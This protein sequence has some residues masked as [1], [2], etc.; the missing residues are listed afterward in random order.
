MAPRGAG[1]RPPAAWEKNSGYRPRLRPPVPFPD[2][3]L[4]PV[5]ARL[6][7]LF[8][9]RLL[10][11]LAREALFRA[12][13]F[14]ARF[15]VDELDER[16]RA[17]LPDGRFVARVPDA[18]FRDADPPAF[19]LRVAAAFRADAERADLDRDAAARPPLRPPFRAGAAFV[20]LPRPEPRFRP[21]PDILFS[22]AH[23]RRSASFLGTP[24][25]S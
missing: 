11:D 2:F 24:R 13:P 1:E 22:V 9:A 25:L 8:R 10:D 3:E 4:L 17:V 15:R 6:P 16:F 23:A 5:R 12:V 14:E 18:R 21:P 7:V 19:R 20:F